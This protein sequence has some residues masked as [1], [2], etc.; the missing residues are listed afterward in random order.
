[1]KTVSCEIKVTFHAPLQFVFSWCTDFQP[2]DSRLEKEDYKRKIVERSSRR[3]IFEDLREMQDGWSWQRTVVLLHPPN[4]W[5]MDSVGNRRDSKAD[6]MLTSIAGGRTQL[7]LRWKVRPK[8][9]AASSLSKTE[10][11]RSVAS[12]WKKFAAALERDYKRR[13][14]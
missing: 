3:A 4:R 11:E 12:A 7:N 6:Y 14:R 5:H 10:R 9:S 2:S 13:A 8:T 1:M